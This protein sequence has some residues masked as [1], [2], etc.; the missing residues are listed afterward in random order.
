MPLE[1][2][3]LRNF[4]SF[5]EK[6][7]EFCPGTNLILGPNGSGKTSILEA[8]NILLKGN[9]FRVKETKE[10]INFNKDFYKIY[11]VGELNGKKL[12]LEVENGAA[13]RLLSKR[14]LEDISIKQEDLYFYQLVISKNL[15]MIEGEPELRRDFFN[16][17]MFHV[18]PQTK[19]LHNQYQK[20]LKQRNKSL[21]NK[22]SDKEI[23]LWSKEVSTIGLELSLQHYEFFKAFKVH[24]KEYIEKVVSVGSFPF[25]DQIDITFTKGWDRT[26]KLEESLMHCLDKDMALGYTSK[27]P[28]RMDFTF[29]VNNKN[30][31][32]NLSRGQLKILI[33]LVFLS[34]SQIIKSLT[35]KE[36]V[37][38]MDDLGSELDRHNLNSIINH[39]LET[40]SQIILTGIEGE[41]MHKSVTKLTNFTKINL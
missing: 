27:G 8:L 23:A 34:N 29:K 16:D 32:T 9:S 6:S 20:A 31:S 17:L 13:K 7:F 12:K 25:L 39:I 19:K 14:T 33:L 35:G 40:E 18:K 3:Q 30:A 41:E 37:L 11:S 2:L 5:Q 38:L 26:K 24:V 22:L 28:H 15:Q 21:K 10:C 1:R 36:S 4:R